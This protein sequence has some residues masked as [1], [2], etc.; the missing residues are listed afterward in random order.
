MRGVWGVCIKSVSIYCVCHSFSVRE[1]D[2]YTSILGSIYAHMAVCVRGRVC[3]KSKVCGLY[4][5]LCGRKM[6]A[7]IVCACV[8]ACAYV[9]IYMWR[10]S[11]GIH[12]VSYEIISILSNH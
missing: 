8:C 10:M 11:C 1:N 2:I 5:S 12:I 6:S 7:E 4:V 9:E 3:G